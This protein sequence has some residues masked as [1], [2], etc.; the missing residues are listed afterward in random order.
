[1]RG[2]AAARKQTLSVQSTP[3]IALGSQLKC[4]EA[5]AGS[6]AVDGSDAESMYCAALD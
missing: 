6:I 2:A 5:G 4:P 3:W 1:M